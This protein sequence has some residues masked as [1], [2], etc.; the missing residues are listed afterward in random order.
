[1]KCPVCDYEDIPDT[2]KVCPR[3][4]A[5]LFSSQPGNANIKVDVDIGKIEGSG[6]AKGLEIGKA[7]DIYVDLDPRQKNQQKR[8]RKAVLEIVWKSWIEGVLE[9]IEASHTSLAH[10]APLF[11]LEKLWLPEAVYGHSD[12]ANQI[13]HLVE[14]PATQISRK[15]ITEI[16]TDSGNSL[17]ILGQPGAGKT[18]SL[19]DIARDK[20]RQAWQNDQASIPIVLN[21]AGWAES[22]STLSNWIAYELSLPQYGIPR[23][24][25][26]DWIKQGELLLLLDGLDE[27][28]T[29]FR[30]DCVKAINHYSDTNF[31]QIAVCSR[32]EEY[33]NLNFQDSENPEQK[34]LHLRQA[35]LLKQ[36]SSEQVRNYFDLAG[37][38]L[39]TLSQ[40]LQVDVQLEELMK[41]PLVLAILSVTYKNVTIDKLPV[42][43]LKSVDDWRNQIFEA[44]EERMF[45]YK[46]EEE[47]PFEREQTTGWLSWLAWGMI[48][49]NQSLFQIERLQPSWLPTKGWQLG[50]VMASRLIITL[51]GAIVG[52]VILGIA[53]SITGGRY[54]IVLGFIQGLAGGVIAGSICG[55]IEVLWL[56]HFNH[57]RFVRSNSRVS[58][59]SIKFIVIAISVWLSVII[60]FGLLSLVTQGTILN[61][62]FSIGQGI[63]VGLILALATGW[64]FAYSPSEV[65]HELSNDIQT[66]ERLNWSMGRA[67][68]IGIQGIVIGLIS[69][70]IA[71]FVARNTPLVQP[72][73]ERLGSFWIVIPTMMLVGATFI[74]LAAIVLGGFRGSAIE[75]KKLRPNQGFYTS[76]YNAGFT[77]VLIGGLFC[78]LGTFLGW[79]I[80]GWEIAVTMG[81]YGIFFGVIAA[82]WYGGFFIVQHSI[83]RIMLW[84]LGYTPWLGQFTK[85]LDY[86][87]RHIFLRKVG[88]G[89]IFIHRYLQ[90]HFI[91]KKIPKGS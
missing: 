77:M 13:A 80:G 12:A 67:V 33:L 40:A 89:Y 59:T 79:I 69:G 49:H 28:P 18:V 48:E 2:T 6:I 24:I 7:R 16:F 62:I 57:D 68:R 78:T 39:A 87:A 45:S 53:N 3:C 42:R 43:Q 90:E 44:Y 81:L 5:S 30:M 10:E 23:D 64:I 51:F 1:M 63:Q 56:M 9:Q 61:I 19:L 91:K 75:T 26:L 31:A 65:R 71:A 60:G 29:E 82:M 58:Q 38:S 14:E 88:G 32:Y 84:R 72:L 37:D 50:Y 52:G 47:S 35:V 4:L 66:V 22:R 76:V 55:V 36:L 70:I 20:L 54:F 83:L 46:K 25:G 34:Q 86:C 15:P 8:Y 17:L 11:R 73:E 41:I 74:G 21:L 27:V 85:F